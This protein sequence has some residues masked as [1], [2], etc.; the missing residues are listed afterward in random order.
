ML[1]FN[2]YYNKQKVKTFYFKK[3]ISSLTMY[4]SEG[5]FIL[6]IQISI[7]F[8]LLMSIHLKRNLTETDL[9]KCICFIQFKNILCQ[10]PNK[11]I[12]K[13]NFLT[14]CMLFKFKG[15]ILRF[16]FSFFEQRYKIEDLARNEIPESY[17]L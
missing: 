2:S 13:N 14:F 4:N 10:N 6:Y 15:S 5:D 17:I 12:L 1:F 8:R 3:F 9:R 7:L 11:K 16:F